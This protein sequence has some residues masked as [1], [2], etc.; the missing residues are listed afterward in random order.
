MMLPRELWYQIQES[1]PLNDLL[2]LREVNKRLAELVL[3]STAWKYLCDDRWLNLAAQDPLAS[4]PMVHSYAYDFYKE[5]YQLDQALLRSLCRS[6]NAT[7]SKSFWLEFSDGVRRL[8]GLKNTL[9]RSFLLSWTTH[10]HSVEELTMVRQLFWHARHKHFLQICSEGNSV[11]SQLTITDAEQHFFLPLACLDPSF[12]VLL[13]RR[14]FILSEVDRY[15]ATTFEN[16][17]TKFNNKLSSLRLKYLATALFTVWVKNLPHRDPTYYREDFMITR[18]YAGET[19]GHLLVL[20]SIIQTISKRYGIT[21][22]LSEFCLCFADTSESCSLSYEQ[23]LESGASYFTVV[24]GAGF[25]VFKERDIANSVGQG[26]LQSRLFDNERLRHR[27]LKPISFMQLK[28]TV[29]DLLLNHHSKSSWDDIWEQS[30]HEKI[31]HYPY[32]ENPLPIQTIRYLTMLNNSHF[33]VKTDGLYTGS[34]CRN[35][36]ASFPGDSIYFD[37]SKLYHQTN[38]KRWLINFFDGFVEFKN[39]QL[40]GTFVVCVADSKLG[41]II[42]I[43]ETSGYITLMDCTGQLFKEHFSAVHEYSKDEGLPL[44]YFSTFHLGLIFSHVNEITKRL[45]V[46]KLIYKSI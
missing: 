6:I 8:N 40:A 30:H 17:L 22:Y 4:L 19:Q 12:D 43:D 36:V 20:L 15:V 1:L 46:K 11:N 33:T 10:E 13:Q 27:F 5:Q 14:T 9:R 38:Y 26:N 25:V 24:P 41:C 28:R 16:D 2:R 34:Q 42:D 45:V 3:D 32:S 31:V 23:I 37:D 44:P 29:I 21:T 35:I 18:V 7:S 39:T